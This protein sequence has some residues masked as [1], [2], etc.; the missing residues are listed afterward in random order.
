MLHILEMFLPKAFLSLL[1]KEVEKML[2][3]TQ[4]TLS[5]PLKEALG[6]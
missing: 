6:G 2:V 4:T 1:F 3:I 5:L